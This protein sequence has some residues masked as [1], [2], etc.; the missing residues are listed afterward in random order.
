M[1]TPIRFARWTCFAAVALTTG[2]SCAPTDNFE[3]GYEALAL[4]NYAQAIRCFDAALDE[5]DGEPVIEIEFARLRALARRGTSNLISLIETTERSRSHAF[6]DRDFSVLASELFTA[7]CYCYAQTLLEYGVARFA[8]NKRLS[9]NLEHVRTALQ[10]YEH[11]GEAIS[12]LPD[13]N[14][15]YVC[16]RETRTFRTSSNCRDCGFR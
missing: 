16:I 15:G 3:E 2:S 9:N 10:V 13:G 12:C 1:L 6:T 14:G 11:T 8:G 4:G 5:P 7:R